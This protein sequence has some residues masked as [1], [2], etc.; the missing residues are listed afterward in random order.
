[1]KKIHKFYIKFIFFLVNVYKF[2]RNDAQNI[3]Y[4]QGRSR[5][6]FAFARNIP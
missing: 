4:N 5:I 3:T 1:M 2:K 6:I